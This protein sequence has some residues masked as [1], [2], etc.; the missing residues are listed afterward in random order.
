MYSIDQ[1]IE[2]ACLYQLSQSQLTALRFKIS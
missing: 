2:I 1:S